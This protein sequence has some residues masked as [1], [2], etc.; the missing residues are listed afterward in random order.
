MSCFGGFNLH[1]LDFQIAGTMTSRTSR[2][3]AR[4]REE[5]RVLDTVIK[6]YRAEGDM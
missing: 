2:L 3:L 1:F 5:A 6:Q 4:L